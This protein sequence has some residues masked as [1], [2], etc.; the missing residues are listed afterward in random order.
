MT[1]VDSK[2]DVMDI[3]LTQFGK[4]L[5]AKGKWKPSYYSF[6]D[7]DVIYDATYTGITEAQNAAQG[8][9]TGS[10]R[11]RTQYVFSG[12]E[13]EIKKLME[14]APYG[15]SEKDRISLQATDDR[16]YSLSLPMGRSDIGN[17]NLPA[18]S[19][20]F[21]NGQLTGSVP[22]STSSL[23]IIPIVQLEAKEIIYKTD[24]KNKNDEAKEDICLEET[25]NQIG[26]SANKADPSDLILANKI[27][28]DGTYVSIEEDY[29]LL[30]ML[31]K[32]TPFED[33]NL[34]IE[35]FS[36]ENNLK[37]GK[38]VLTP[39][40]FLKKKQLIVDDILIDDD[41]PELNQQ[42]DLTPDFVEYFFNVY[43]DDEIA[44][45]TLCKAVV[46]RR[47]LGLYAPPL[48]CPEPDPKV[49]PPDPYPTDTVT[50]PCFDEEPEEC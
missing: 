11:P 6:F 39:L 31:E 48:K 13:T 27:Y 25:L 15:G 35:V 38:E 19:I 5:L 29:L 8:R 20:T 45:E 32:N 16:D 33:E 3:E 10:I 18:W 30:E 41:E 49:C 46:Q 34:E 2:E 23:G 44:Q 12:I 7:D 47:D 4:H 36:I 37:T 14:R 40:S 42:P 9:I 43:V 24:I 50:G 17:Q 26:E 1:F 28:D 21:L 22:Y